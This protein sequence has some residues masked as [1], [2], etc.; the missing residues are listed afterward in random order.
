MNR[1]RVALSLLMIVYAMSL[2]AVGQANDQSKRR[3]NQPTTVA[4]PSSG[5]SA[6]AGDAWPNCFT[7]FGPQDSVEPSMPGAV[8]PADLGAYAGDCFL[9]AH[10]NPEPIGKHATTE[11]GSDAINFDDYIEYQQQQLTS[12]IPPAP[13]IEVEMLD[14]DYYRGEFDVVGN[15][16][17]DLDGINL[18]D[19]D[20]DAAEVSDRIAADFA[21]KK[22][23]A[24]EVAADETEE[25]EMTIDS[26]LF[27]SLG[28]S[29]SQDAIDADEQFY[30]QQQEPVKQ[31]LPTDHHCPFVH[32]CPRSMSCPLFD[33]C[34][35]LMRDMGVIEEEVTEPM[36]T[37]APM[38]T[39]TPAPMLNDVTLDADIEDDGMYSAEM[40]PVLPRVRDCGEID[41]KVET[42]CPAAKKEVEAKEFV[43]YEAGDYE[44]LEYDDIDYDGL[45][46]DG[47]EYER[48]VYGLDYDSSMLYPSVPS[49]VD[50]T[51]EDGCPNLDSYNPYRG[52]IYE[53]E[54]SDVSPKP[55][56]I[57]DYDFDYNFQMESSQLADDAAMWDCNL[58]ESSKI[59]HDDLCHPAPKTAIAPPQAF[60][61][62]RD[63]ARSVF[64]RAQQELSKL[65]QVSLVEVLADKR[66]SAGHEMAQLINMANDGLTQVRRVDPY[67]PAKV[68]LSDVASHVEWFASRV[69]S[70]VQTT[71]RGWYAE[72][73][74]PWDVEATTIRGETRDLNLEID[75]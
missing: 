44:G 58:A 47:L 9:S 7:Y 65:W 11:I 50:S 33:R 38:P 34:R 23:D 5:G 40:L 18:E 22:A 39:A 30:T 48:D 45:G 52:T 21:A 46:Y 60:N 4:E 69:N 67:G 32:G 54:A 27:D 15:E 49:I 56:V 73:D 10:G 13:P 20:F 25:A 17:A 36:V 62:V 71:R 26:V 75:F 70:Y 35:E 3:P 29:L 37:P 74:F 12:D 51:Y 59:K 16:A 31:Q 61:Q 64:L 72:Y 19:R 14:E 1:S 57:E 6:A 66:H 24:K 42:K 53:Y 68:W 28:Q 8:T 55:F 63:V 2:I 41:M 43:D